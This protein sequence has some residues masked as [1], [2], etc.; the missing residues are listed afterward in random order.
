M[1]NLGIIFT[2]IPKVPKGGIK[3]N[4]EQIKE[5]LQSTGMPFFENTYLR[6][7]RIPTSK[8]STF[9]LDRKDEALKDNMKSI[10]QEFIERAGRYNNE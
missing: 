10:C 8:L 5:A 4:M 7:N 3:N 2:R 1:D 9:I 6:A